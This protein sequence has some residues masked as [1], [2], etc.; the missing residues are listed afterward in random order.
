M[1]VFVDRWSLTQVCIYF[2]AVEG[3]VMITDKMGN[4][5]INLNK[6]CEKE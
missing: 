3:S 6:K 1:V 2:G 4:M 5:F